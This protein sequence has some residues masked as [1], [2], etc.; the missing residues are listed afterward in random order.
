M[1]QLNL[2]IFFNINGVRVKNF[3]EI[4]K[5]PSLAEFRKNYSTLDHLHILNQITEKSQVYWINI[6]V[7]FIDYNKAFDSVHHY[8][9]KTTL[10][11]QGVPTN[12]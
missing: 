5:S 7:A 8:Y 3:L 2:E 12:W 11:V 1:G 10:Q 4:Q 6:N 9:I